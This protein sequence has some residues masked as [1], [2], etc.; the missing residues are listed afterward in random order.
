MMV[1]EQAEYAIGLEATAASQQRLN[2]LLGATPTAQLE[3][4]RETMQFLTTAFEQGKITA[5]QYT[6][7][8]QTALGTVNTGVQESGSQLEEMAKRAGQNI[9]DAFAQFLYKP[10]DGGLKG[11]LQG[12]G[13][14][15]RQMAA[16][17]AAAQIAQSIFNWGSTG[18]GSGSLWGDLAVAIFGGAKATGGDVIAGR[19]YLVGEQEP[20]MFVPR[21]AGTIVPVSAMGGGGGG[22]TT[23][24]TVNV[25]AGSPAETRR[26]AAAGAREALG[27]M[28]AAQRYR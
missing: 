5:L 27:A 20:E 8:V 18:G 11:M 25:P 22:S 6:E 12:F 9:Q 10:F 1:A 28:A 26:A 2:E 23:N 21:T 19:S 17:A 14:M 13:D 7:A 4:T 3:S 16:Q 15:L 24:I